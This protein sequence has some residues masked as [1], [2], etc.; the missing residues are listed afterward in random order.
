MKISVLCPSRGRPE[1]AKRMLDSIYATKNGS[2]VE[3]LFYLNE[4]DPRL[5][6]YPLDDKRCIVHIGKDSP[7]AWS[8]NWLAGKATGDLLM[9]MGDDNIFT[10][11]CW[12]EKYIEAA[13]QYPDGIFVISCP[14]GRTKDGNPHPTVGR[15]WVNTLGYFVPPIFLHWFVDSWT[16]YMAQS[17]GRFIRLEDVE[18]KHD[19]DDA[20]PTSLRIRENAWYD[21][22]RWIAQYLQRYLFLDRKLLKLAIKRGEV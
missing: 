13:K 2:E 18:I 7:P 4:D 3:V 14:D 22:D 21:R 12:D 1:K 20:D 6:E 9:L 17:L 5:Q 8:W 15:G 10:T 11:P 19:K 16:Q